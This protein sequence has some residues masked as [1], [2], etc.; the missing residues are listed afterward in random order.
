MYSNGEGRNAYFDNARYV[1][2]FLVVVGHMM[3]P[4]QP[5]FGG[6]KSCYFFIYLFHMYAFAIISG[7]FSRPALSTEQFQKSLT[8]FLVPFLVFEVA[9][10]VIYHLLNNT[11]ELSYTLLLPYKHL[12]FLVSLLTWRIL[13]PWIESFRFPILLS[14]VLALVAGYSSEIGTTMSFSR[15]LVFLPFFLIGYKMERR[16]FE[17]LTTTKSRVASGAILLCAAIVA[18]H[19]APDLSYSFLFGK[20]SYQ[21]L[22]WTE[23]HAALYRAL[24]MCAS[25][26]CAMSLL[27]IIPKKHSW[28][29]VMGK[30]SLYPYLI[31]QAIIMIALKLKFHK[32]L[33]QHFDPWAILL[34]ILVAATLVHL[35]LSLRPVVHIMRPLIQPKSKHLGL[36]V[37]GV[38]LIVLATSLWGSLN[39]FGVKF[40]RQSELTGAN[41]GT[42]CE[43]KLC[44][45][46][47][48]AGLAVEFNR[49][50]KSRRIELGATPVGTYE[51]LFFKNNYLVGTTTIKPKT[52][53]G[54][55]P[56]QLVSSSIQVPGSARRGYD[57]ILIRMIKH[58]LDAR[59]G[60]IR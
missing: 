46:V 36:I 7:H 23:P 6:A 51:I 5:R 3:E 15:T 27:A 24:S 17:W 54:Y 11:L 14:I 31:H 40:I 34:I 47:S 8:R 44:Y 53:E 12:W 41:E 57:K 55:H 9:Y 33:L 43:Q 22:R 20:N 18:W 50:M 19:W 2:I 37:T 30:R 26:V 58:D 59:L 60:F 1:L 49:R 10:G 21:A 25:L 38:F 45:T 56:N 42:S 4:F 13:L 29:S 32:T 48:S 39:Y 16:H 28:F 52:I 35:L